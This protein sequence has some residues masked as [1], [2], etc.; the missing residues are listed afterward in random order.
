MA[1]AEWKRRFFKKYIF[2]FYFLPQHYLPFGWELYE[3]NNFL[4]PYPKDPTYQR[5]LVK[6]GQV[7]FLEG[8]VNGWHTTDDGRQPWATQLGDLNIL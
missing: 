5:A 4:S 6:I 8:D 3:I 1:H 7:V 2:F